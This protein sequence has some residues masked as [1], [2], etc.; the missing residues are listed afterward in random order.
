MI[1]KYLLDEVL[2]EP[3]QHG[4]ELFI[5]SGYASSD[6]V[7]ELLDIYKNLKINL[8]IGMAGQSGIGINQH[9]KFI[10]F[11]EKE[12]ENR[13]DCRYYPGGEGLHSKLYAWFKNNKPLKGFN[14][15]VNFTKN[16]FKSGQINSVSEE[17]PEEIKNYFEEIYRYSLELTNPDLENFVEIYSEKEMI[18]NN[19][20]LNLEELDLSLFKEI[21]L[22]ELSNKKCKISLLTRNGEIHK[23]SGLNWGHRGKRNRNEAYIPVPA[24]KYYFFPEKGKHFN[25]ITDDSIQLEVVRA[26]ENG[27]AIETY[28]NN[29]ILGTYFRNRI[30][31][32]NGAFIEKE[33]LEKYGR[34]S[35]VFFKLE[36]RKYYMDFSV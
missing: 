14:G 30:G 11:E 36:D 25:I 4:D 20:R 9:E 31:V 34:T 7:K 16:G 28:E 23:K 33:D 17:D 27:K 24:D 18:E 13:F 15:S 19:I 12:Y 26:Q 22:D 35:V 5:I 6:L 21:E 2:I 3:A 8:I 1:N 10:S 32:K 29:S